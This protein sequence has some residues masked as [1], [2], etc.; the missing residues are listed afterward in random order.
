MK[1]NKDIKD[2]DIKDLLDI[3]LEVEDKI[4]E[5]HRKIIEEIRKKSKTSEINVPVSR[6]INPA[7]LS[8]SLCGNTDN[9]YVI[10]TI[11]FEDEK[12]EEIVKKVL[13]EIKKDLEDLDSFVICFECIKE[14]QEEGKMNFNILTYEE[15]E[16]ITDRIEEEAEEEALR[17]FSPEERKII[18]KYLEHLNKR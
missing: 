17:K 1:K 10:E 5:L 2:I 16:D 9:L 13:K 15:I 18:E 4:A 12:E 3:Y 7:G 8:C 14:L 11:A 6:V